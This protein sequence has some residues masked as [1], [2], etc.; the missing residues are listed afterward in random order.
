MSKL[1]FSLLTL[2][3][4]AGNSSAAILCPSASGG[5][6]YNATSLAS[7]AVSSSCKNGVVVTS[8]LSAVQSNISSATVH[9]WPADRA[10]KV[11]KGGSIGNTTAFDFA[12][13]TSFSAA[14]QAFT[15][16]GTVSGLK[17]TTPDMFGAVPDAT[18]AVGVASGTDS[19]TAIQKA[20]NAVGSNGSVEFTGAYKTTAELVIPATASNVRLF[21]KSRAFIY[22]GHTGNGIKIAGDNEGYS[23]HT[24]ERLTISGPNVSYP[25]NGYTPTSL[26]AAIKIGTE[27]VT[28][29]NEGYGIKIIACDLT[30]FKYGLWIRNSIALDMHDFTHIRFNQYGIFSGGG[31]VNAN[32]FTNSEVSNNRIAGLYAVPADGEANNNVLR[33]ML[34]QTNVPYVLGGA[35]TTDG[36]PTAFDNTG[37][38]VGM[39]VASGA[40]GTNIH[41]V[42][43]ACYFEDHNYS[44][45]LGTL[46]EGFKFTNGTRFA[47]GGV[48]LVRVGGIRMTGS[49]VQG[50]TFKDVLMASFDST[51]PNVE[52][53]GANQVFNSFI[54]CTGFNF[55]PSAI[56]HTGSA[57]YI[58]NSI[59]FAG[60]HGSRVGMLAV[61]PIG[62]YENIGEGLTTAPIPT[63]QGIGTTTA[64]LHALGYGEIIFSD[65]VAAAA[66]DTMI[67]TITGAG[68]SRILT[69]INFQ[70]TRAVKVK[71]GL[72]G[73]DPIR[74]V[75]GGGVEVSIPYGGMLMLYVTGAGRFY[76]IGRNF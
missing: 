22:C 51:T 9:S 32:R 24:I 19:I 55:I 46:T 34:F 75:G 69:L 56:T 53:D 16:S 74:M 41:W 76:E 3:V 61:P 27:G 57:L 18:W 4:L 39:F 54:G 47:P 71:A 66:T 35:G 65:L 49:A 50:N 7:A 33:S 72:N 52:T 44:V 26:G 70:A 68:S 6:P 62:V 31:V 17:Y 30:N 25:T 48:G 28:A 2:L 23:G 12:S 59:L 73:G 20:I 64:N 60:T 36:W 11:E 21:S 37:V 63:L 42:I 67:T 15:G 10:L 45:W 13:G 58:E 14:G 5:A 43:D 8:A 1:L 29:H 38:G 40:A